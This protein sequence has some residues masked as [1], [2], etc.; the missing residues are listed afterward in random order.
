MIDNPYVSDSRWGQF[1]GSAVREDQTAIPRRAQGLLKFSDLSLRATDGTQNLTI[2]WSF[3][4]KEIGSMSPSGA[5]ELPAG[6]RAPV[7]SFVQGADSV[8]FY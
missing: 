6:P 4:R 5:W 7:S 1:R 2:A 8:E 3:L